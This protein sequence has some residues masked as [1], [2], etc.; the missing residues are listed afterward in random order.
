M[1]HLKIKK[2]SFQQTLWQISKS[3]LFKLPFDDINISKKKSKNIIKI[4]KN[5]EYR[6]KTSCKKLY[7]NI[8]Q[9]KVELVRL[10]LVE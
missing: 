7:Q 3:I 1:G 8:Y 9:G 5:N 4:L 10:G 6:S 2:I